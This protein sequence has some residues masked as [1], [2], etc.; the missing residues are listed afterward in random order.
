MGAELALMH[1]PA[2]EHQDLVTNI[3]SWKS[4]RRLV[5]KVFGGII[6]LH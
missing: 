2:K 5:P 1:L 6:V 3:R 4:Q